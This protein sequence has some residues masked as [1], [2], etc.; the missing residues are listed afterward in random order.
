MARKALPRPTDTE[1]AI[2]NL[3][4][5]Q[6]GMTAREVADGQKVEYPSAYTMLTIMEK[7]GWVK[8]GERQSPVEFFA[9][10]DEADFKDGLLRDF[11]KRVFGINSAKLVLPAAES[12]RLSKTDREKLRRI[13][14]RTED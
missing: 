10:A 5:R 4:W 1:L 3:L 9:I 12:E 7:K 6:P 2:L 14:D 11:L 13:I 8:R